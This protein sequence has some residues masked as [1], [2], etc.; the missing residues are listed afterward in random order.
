MK[1]LNKFM[2]SNKIRMDFN[3][4][5]RLVQLLIILVCFIGQALG[6]PTQCLPQKY[7][8]VNYGVN[9]SFRVH[10]A[11]WD[12][13]TD[14]YLFAGNE[15]PAGKTKIFSNKFEL[16]IQN[17][18]K[19]FSAKIIDNHAYVMY[20]QTVAQSKN[21]YES[22]LPSIGLDSGASF[23]SSTF[24]DLQYYGYPC[25]VVF[26]MIDGAVRSAYCMQNLQGY[27]VHQDT[28]HQSFANAG[29]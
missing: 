24:Y 26:S 9:F 13:T 23:Y 12:Y 25:M 6:A 15:D 10:V 2:N 1:S 3:S 17:V 20:N 28:Y 21:D 27:H 7:P 14:Q 18:G 8:Y 19:F 22:W 11:D 29:S 5:I 4:T 16:E